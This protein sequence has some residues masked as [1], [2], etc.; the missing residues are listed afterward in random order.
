MCDHG[1][2]M[3]DFLKHS[4]FVEQFLE[5]QFYQ[6]FASILHVLPLS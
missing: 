4:L 3:S 2:W 5:I 6:L 1:N